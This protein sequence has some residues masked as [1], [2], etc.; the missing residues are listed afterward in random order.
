MCRRA[1]N[2]SVLSTHHQMLCCVGGRLRISIL[3]DQHRPREVSLALVRW[4]T[5]SN[6]GRLYDALPNGGTC[7]A[8]LVK[9]SG[10]GGQNYWLGGK[11]SPPGSV[12]DGRSCCNL[13]IFVI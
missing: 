6:L 3:T 1:L 8:S 4:G 13:W 12:L 2:M 7:F 5:T 9:L 11:C 10:R